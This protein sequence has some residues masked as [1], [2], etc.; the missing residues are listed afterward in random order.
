[1]QRRHLRAQNQT[2]ELALR[3]V[4]FVNI[5]LGLLLYGILRAIID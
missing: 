1:M 4:L 3:D 5:W 2:F